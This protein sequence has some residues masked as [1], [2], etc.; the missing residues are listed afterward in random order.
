MWVEG[1]LDGE[2]L[3]VFFSGKLHTHAVYFFDANA[4]LACHSAAHGH[5][6]FQNLSA[7]QLTAAQLVGVIRIEQNQRVQVAVARVEHVQAAQ[8]VFGFHFG[9][10]LQDVG[11]ALARDGR[12]HAHVVG[13]DAARRR[14]GVFAPAPEFQALGFV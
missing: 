3:F 11:Q 12:V 9:D 6:G 1:A 5:A 2:H 4:V 13:A 7:K 14:K 8:R 10:G